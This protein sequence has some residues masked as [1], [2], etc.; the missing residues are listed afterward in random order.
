MK[1]PEEEKKYLRVTEV[2]SL[3]EVSESR[4]YKIMRQLNKELEKQGKIVTA[5]RIS[6]RYLTTTRSPFL[7][8]RSPL[9]S[10]LAALALFRAMAA[11]FCPTIPAHVVRSSPSC[12]VTWQTKFFKE[13]ERLVSLH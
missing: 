9:S 12:I 1:K 10:G 5:G 8:M 4:A 6:K 7:P 13:L 3:L 11:I 2:A